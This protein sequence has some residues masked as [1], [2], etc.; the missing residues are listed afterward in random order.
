VTPHEWQHVVP[1]ELIDDPMLT[2]KNLKHFQ[3]TF[4]NL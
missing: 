1:A 2:N 3:D 4:K